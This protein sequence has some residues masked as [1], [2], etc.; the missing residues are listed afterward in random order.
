MTK[1]LVIFQPSG[2]RGYMEERK[3]LID[4]A[5]ELGVDIE[6][7]CGSKCAMGPALEGANNLVINE[8]LYLLL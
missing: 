4:A 7:V 1:H 8:A 6:S 5:Q 2:K 3:T